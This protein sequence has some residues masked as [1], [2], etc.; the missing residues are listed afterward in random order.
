MPANIVNDFELVQIQIG[1]H[2]ILL[3]LISIGNNV[4]QL[5]VKLMPIIKPRQAIMPRLIIELSLNN[6]V[7]IGAT[8]LGAVLFYPAFHLSEK[9]FRL[10]LE[11]RSRMAADRAPAETSSE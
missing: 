6:T 4:R 8:V 9:V 11:R 2:V 5:V 7:V 3:I 1:Q 10:Y